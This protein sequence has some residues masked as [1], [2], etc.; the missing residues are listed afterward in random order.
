[1]RMQKCKKLAE[2]SFQFTTINS[3]YDPRYLR[4]VMY[5]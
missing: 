5:Y 1:M 4:G 3:I 2:A